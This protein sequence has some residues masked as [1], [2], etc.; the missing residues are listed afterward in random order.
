MSTEIDFILGMKTSF[1][2]ILLFVGVTTALHAKTL[3]NVDRKGVG[4]RGYDPVAYFTDAKA[5]P[6]NP[7][8]ASTADGVIYFF[9]S[10]EHKAAFDSTPS[11]YEPQFGGFCA[12]G[13]SRGSLIEIDPTAFQIVDGRLLLQYSKG[14]M[15]KFNKDAVANLQK[16]DQNW[17]VLLEKKGK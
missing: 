15:N 13:L 14:V 3:I 11:K 2:T 12:Y 10:P 6:G 1:L 7:A 5:V 9:A 4:I 17:P 8:I 16:A